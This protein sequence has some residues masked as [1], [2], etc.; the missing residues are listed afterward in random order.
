MIAVNKLFELALRSYPL[1]N[2]VYNTQSK[3]CLPINE[4]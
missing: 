2:E 1:S 3:Q 4:F